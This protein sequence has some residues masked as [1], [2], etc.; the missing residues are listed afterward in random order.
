MKP[1]LAD[2]LFPKVD[3]DLWP[4]LPSLHELSSLKHVLNR[5]IVNNDLAKVVGWLKVK[6][7][8]EKVPTIAKIRAAI[9]L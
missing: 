8:G 1:K 9:A 3:D 4:V 5:V 2:Y 7:C 6:I